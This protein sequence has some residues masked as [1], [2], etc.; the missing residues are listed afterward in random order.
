[1]EQDHR[2]W[3]GRAPTRAERHAAA[4]MQLAALALDVLELRR[5]GEH[6]RAHALTVKRDALARATYRAAVAA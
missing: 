2:R 5:R 6:A 3:T 4:E 1:M